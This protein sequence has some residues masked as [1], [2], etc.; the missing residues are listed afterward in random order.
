MA[1][2]E[3]CDKLFTR[4]HSFTIAEETNKTKTSKTTT[5]QKKKL[6]FT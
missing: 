3:V 6:N 2:W 1:D 5:K 4:D